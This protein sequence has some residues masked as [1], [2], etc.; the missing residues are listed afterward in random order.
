MRIRIA[1]ADDLELL[2]TLRLD[3]FRA[4]SVTLTPE[5]KDAITGQLR[6]YIPK[7]LTE[8]DFIAVLAEENGAVLSTA[9]LILVEKPANASFP[10]GK[11]GT[12]LNVFT[13]PQYRRKGY[14]EKVI[15]ALISEAKKAG[16]SQLELSAT[17]CGEPLYRKLGFTVPPE[18]SMRLKIT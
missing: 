18:A 1:T 7:H 12:V 14:A 17:K 3:F 6:S 15:L 4:N 13:Y 16:I 10:S 2:I 9:F 8:G 11:T 5:Q